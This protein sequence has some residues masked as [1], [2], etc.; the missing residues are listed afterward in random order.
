MERVSHP[1]RRPAHPALG[2]RR[3]NR[4]LYRARR[5]DRAKR[6]HR[7]ANPRRWQG[8]GPLQGTDDRRTAVRLAGLWLLLLALVASTWAEPPV[9]IRDAQSAAAKELVDLAKLD[10][11][12]RFDLRYATPDNFTKATLYPVAKAYLN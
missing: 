12:L 1:L 8:R 3:A 9:A 5:I 6:T 4:R 7:R 2:E 11:T 10:P